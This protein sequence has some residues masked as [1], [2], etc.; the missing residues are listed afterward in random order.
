[1]SS[2]IRPDLSHGPGM[3][4]DMRLELFDVALGHIGRLND[5]LVNRHLE[6]TLIA[7]DEQER[8][9]IT[10]YDLPTI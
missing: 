9:G 5:D 10:L 2:Y 7:E 4:L 8:V 3:D 1:M 6:V